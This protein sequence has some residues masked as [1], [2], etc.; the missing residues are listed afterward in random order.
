MMA[1]GED[2]RADEDVGARGALEQI[3][4]PAPRGVA[5]HAQDP[6]LREFLAE[7]QLDPLRPP[8]KCLQIVVAALRTGAWNAFGQSA[9]MATQQP[10]G[11]V[12][13]H[14]RRAAPAALD[15]A[16]C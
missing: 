10:R 8:S 15:P 4:E 1:L 7:Q 12:Q 13:D 16:A 9:M 5:I 2:L 3:F 6:R 11:Q 14:V